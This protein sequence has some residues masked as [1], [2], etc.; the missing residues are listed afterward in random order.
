MFSF[1]WAV[2]CF[3]IAF[4]KPACGWVGSDVSEVTCSQGLSECTVA[5][6]MP[7]AVPDSDVA[8][9]QMVTAKVELCCKDDTPCTLCLLIDAELAVRAAGDADERLQSGRGDEADAEEEIISTA[10]VTLCYK[11][12]P[13][14]PACK[15]VD[16]TIS[17]T[18][19]KVAKVSLVITNPSGVSFGSIVYVYPS[20]W[21]HPFVEVEAPSLNEVCSQNLRKPINECHVPTVNSAINERMNQVELTFADRNKVCIQYEADGRCQIWETKTI[22]LHSVTP[23]LCLQVWDDDKP[24][25]SQSCPFKNMGFL[26]KNIWQN[27][28]ASV[29]HGRMNDKGQM[30]L[31]NLS[32]PC[33]LEGEVWP[34]RWTS[35]H[36]CT[37]IKGF[38]QQ[39]ENTTWEQK[40]NLQWVKIG[41][42]EDINLQ[43][44]PCVMVNLTRGGL[45]LGPFCSHHSA[46][47]R[48]NLLAVAGLLV[49]AMTALMLCLLHGFIKKWASRSFSGGHVKT[50]RKGHIVLLSPPDGISEVC[51][52]GSLLRSQGFSVSVDQWSRMEQCKLGPLPWLHSQL[53]HIKILGG[54]VVLVLTRKALGLAHEWSQQH[55]EAIQAG[56]VDGNVPLPPFSDVFVA[57]L[58]LILGD[59][60]QG[61]TAERFLL[62]TFEHDVGQPPGSLPELFRGLR[63]FQLPS[64]MKTFLCELAGGGKGKA[65]G[66]RTKAG[67]KWATFDGWR[68]KTKNATYSQG[69]IPA[70]CKYFE[71]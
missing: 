36:N 44:F 62:V 9:V 50:A 25:R 15:R 59:K 34:C 26:E 37:E 51:G 46:R 33:R 43:L 22:P 68:L 56:R 67:W 39:L 63:L 1:R 7:L 30:L 57:S 23:C 24:R 38:R 28:T 64:Q 53:L 31:W 4:H 35:S 29:G 41:F 2:C 18:S 58:C 21:L 19:P 11:T 32:A 13:T 55:R 17:P 47:W 48:W 60:Q 16:F 6:E 12:P 61:R 69:T 14:I 10:S 54:R 66:G 65:K 27:L 3:L 40:S 70:Q 8:D 42:F 45:H 5:P 52:L 49:I 71:I 20:E